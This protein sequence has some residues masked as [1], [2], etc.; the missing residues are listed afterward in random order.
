MLAIRVTSIRKAPAQIGSQGR[1]S[2]RMA[3]SSTAS[4][5]MVIIDLNQYSQ[6]TENPAQSPSQVLA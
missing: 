4:R 1:K 6:P 5:V 2:C 3:P